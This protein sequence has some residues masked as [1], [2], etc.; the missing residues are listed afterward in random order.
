MSFFYR[1]EN[2][3]QPYAWG[4]TDAFTDL[5]GWQNPSKEPRAELWMGAHPKAPSI[6]KSEAGHLPLDQWL[7]QQP[8]RLLGKSIDEKFNLKFLFKVLSSAKALSIQV[9]PNLEQAKEGFEEENRKGIALNAPHRNYKDVN[10]KPELICA[11]TPFVAMSGFRPKAE[12]ITLSKNLDCSIWNDHFEKVI[13][14]NT[15]DYRA[16][17]KEAYLGLLRL[18]TEQKAAFIEK[19]ESAL[20]HSIGIQPSTEDLESYKKQSQLSPFLEVFAIKKDYPADIAIFSPLLL[21]LFY[22]DPGQA[23]F[24]QAGIPHAYLRGTG[25]EIMANS[26]NVLRGGLTPK[27]IDVAELS[28]IID[29]RHASPSLV[30][31]KRDQSGADHYQVNINDFDLKLFHLEKDLSYS[32]DN[33]HLSIVLCL[34]GECILRHAAEQINLKAGEAALVVASSDAITIQGEGKLAFASGV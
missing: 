23:L 29:A 20:I 4:T 19:V 16:A 17:L 7:K 11:L 33:Q 12:F 6:V 26:D 30:D 25:L 1:L 34:S 8:R 13:T 22:L 18:P 31:I 14:S 24:M 9:H 27:H 28:K 15:T 5:F 10:H 32:Y 2:Q 3:I 21:N